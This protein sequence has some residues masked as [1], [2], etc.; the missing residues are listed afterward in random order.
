MSLTVTALNR[1]TLEKKYKYLNFWIFSNTWI[2]Y[3]EYS[4]F[5]KIN[6]PDTETWNDV[7]LLH[8]TVISIQQMYG[9]LAKIITV[10]LKQPNQGQPL[11]K[12]NTLLLCYRVQ[13]F[14]IKTWLLISA[15]VVVYENSKEI[16]L[17]VFI[18][19]EGHTM[20]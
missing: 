17:H 9:K 13:S 7:L 11:I 15:P 4:F 1:K 8:A 19:R 16:C 14:R 5:K 20:T 3:L 2:L 12:I 18:M 10:R 6:L